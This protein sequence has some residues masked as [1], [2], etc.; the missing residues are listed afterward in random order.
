M[1]SGMAAASEGFACFKGHREMA[2]KNH[3]KFG[4]AVLNSHASVSG[5]ASAVTSACAWRQRYCR[6]ADDH[7]A[8]ASRRL[9]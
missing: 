9:S 8:C 2:M 6:R 5:A 3:D 4:C 1:G 7:L